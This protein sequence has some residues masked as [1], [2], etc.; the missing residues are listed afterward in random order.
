MD[1]WMKI[2]MALLLGMML[3]FLLPRAKE[4]IKNSP[5]GSSQEWM[6]ALIPLALVAGF[7]TLLVMM[8]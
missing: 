2:G 1:M 6:S 3:L 7:I 4:M 5:K 8:V